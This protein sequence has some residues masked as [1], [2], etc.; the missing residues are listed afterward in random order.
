MLNHA[1]VR[2]YSRKVMQ[3]TIPRSS[4]TA[5]Q[6]QL[7]HTP[8]DTTHCVIQTLQPLHMI[9]Q[10]ALDTHCLMQM[11]QPLHMICHKAA[12][13]M[14]CV[15][16]T[17]DTT[18]SGTGS[19]N[20]LQGRFRIAAVYAI[21]TCTASGMSNVYPAISS[22]KQWC[23]GDGIAPLTHSEL[24]RQTGHRATT[25]TSNLQMRSQTYLRQQLAAAKQCFAPQPNAV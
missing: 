25:A 9:C 1:K 22:C 10:A 14:H 2:P 23:W 24:R 13:T 12:I 11:L 21:T 6:C 16:Q 20:G 19:S 5:G 4:A 3:K 7:Q 15:M 17:P 18:C 8:Q